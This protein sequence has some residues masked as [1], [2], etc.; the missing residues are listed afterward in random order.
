[1][2][3]DLKRLIRIVFHYHTHHFHT[4]PYLL[5]KLQTDITLKRND[6]FMTV[7]DIT[8][9]IMIIT[10]LNNLEKFRY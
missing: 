6:R 10:E 4:Y 9:N 8:M 7:F 3:F 1:M 2:I 5:K